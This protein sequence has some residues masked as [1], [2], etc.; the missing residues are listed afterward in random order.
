MATKS[1]KGSARFKAMAKEATTLCELMQGRTKVDTDELLD[2]EIVLL[3][4]QSLAVVLIVFVYS[5]AEFNLIV[6]AGLNAEGVVVVT[7]IVNRV[8]K[9]LTYYLG[10]DEELNVL[11]RGGTCSSHVILSVIEK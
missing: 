3:L 1:I 2:K 9:R 10:S 7:L 4:A 8:K 6:F 5:V 11:C